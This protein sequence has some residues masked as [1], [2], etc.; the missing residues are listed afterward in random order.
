MDAYRRDPGAAISAQ[1]LRVRSRF[2]ASNHAGVFS[3]WPTI[4]TEVGGF[5]A[6]LLQVVPVK[7][8]YQLTRR[9]A[10]RGAK[11][12]PHDAEDVG[13]TS[14]NDWLTTGK[15]GKPTPVTAA[16]RR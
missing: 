10:D 8:V 6:A 7:A 1:P 15:D 12:G 4:Q 13:T 3:E 14:R 5:I 16:T 9:R 2:I 11:I